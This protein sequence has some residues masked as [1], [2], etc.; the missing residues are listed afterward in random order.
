[1]GLFKRSAILAVAWLVAAGAST[2]RAE[3]VVDSWW[4]VN[5]VQNT[6]GPMVEVEHTTVTFPFDHVDTATDEPTYAQGA[7][8][9][10]RSEDWASFNWGFDHSRSGSDSFASSFGN[11][12]FTLTEPLSYTLQ[13]S[14]TLSGAGTVYLSVHLEDLSQYPHSGTIY[15][16]Q[17]ESSATLNESFALGQA[18]G[19]LISEEEGEL[20]GTLQ[21]DVQYKLGYYYAVSNNPYVPGDAATAE[22]MLSF[23][24]TPEPS[25]L[26]LLATGGLAVLR[27]LRR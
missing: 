20:T 14:Y 25:S 26:M 4:L 6:L 9:F 8:A 21:P 1:M 19:D 16:G 23:T 7:Y 10:T 17:H 13:G 12:H 2:V 15:R 24:L 18:G 27:R 5:Q 3:T 11:I 22:G